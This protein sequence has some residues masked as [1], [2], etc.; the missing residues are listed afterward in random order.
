MLTVE[1]PKLG[2]RT[3]VAFDIAS[4]PAGIIFYRPRREVGCVVG[5]EQLLIKLLWVTLRQH[6]RFGG[7]PVFTHHREVDSAIETVVTPARKKEP[8]AVAAPI[9]LTVRTITVH[10]I[11]R[12]C[13]TSLQVQQPEVGLGMPDREIAIVNLC[14]HQITTVVRGTGEGY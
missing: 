2:G 14:V 6:E 4:Y 10:L 1:I 8:P 9:M 12:S 7:L 5:V 11:H 13:L 3:L